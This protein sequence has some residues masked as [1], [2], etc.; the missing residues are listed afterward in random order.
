MI[1]DIKSTPTHRLLA[2]YRKARRLQFIGNDDCYY[3]PYNPYN[4]ILDVMKAELD[5]REHVVKKGKKK[6]TFGKKKRHK[7]QDLA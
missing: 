3:N 5:T 7:F 4:P 6:S 1:Q 2:M